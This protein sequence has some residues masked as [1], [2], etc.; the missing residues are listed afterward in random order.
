MSALPSVVQIH[1]ATLYEKPC[2]LLG[3]KVRCGG[4]TEAHH[5]ISKGQARGNKKVR[6][7]ID[8]LKVPVCAN[9]N[10]S[11][12]ADT[13]PARR[14]LLEHFVEEVGEDWLREYINVLPWKLQP[15]W[16]TFEGILVA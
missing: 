6:K 4:E 9:H 2:W 5:L 12:L 7:L 8:N 3:Y 15:H 14:I 10:I 13:R 11:K 16:L 1:L